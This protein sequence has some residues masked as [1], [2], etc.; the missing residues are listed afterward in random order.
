VAVRVRV[1]PDGGV[2]RGSIRLLDSTG[3]P[4]LDREAARIAGEMRFWPAEVRG[5]PA[6]GWTVARVVFPNGARP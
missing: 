5:F 2:D 6:I 4:E 3:E 1:L